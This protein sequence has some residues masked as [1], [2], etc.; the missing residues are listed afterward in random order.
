MKKTFVKIGA[1]LMALLVLFSST[2]FLKSTHFCAGEIADVSYFVSSDNCASM[3][4]EVCEDDS[5]VELVKKKSCCD[6]E[7]EI[8][9]GQDFSKEQSGVEIAQPLVFLHDNGISTLPADFFIANKIFQKNG[10]P[11]VSEKLNIL[12]C[13]FLI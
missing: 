13:T 11:P 9:Q 5:S 8:H 2:S 12:Y 7:S 4:E 3:L 1:F 6:T 10:D